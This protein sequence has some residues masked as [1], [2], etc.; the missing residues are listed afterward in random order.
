MGD[1]ARGLGAFEETTGSL[2]FQEQRDAM[3]DAK[4]I[5]RANLVNNAGGAGAGAS[6]ADVNRSH[7]L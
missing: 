7:L 4:D 1:E 5:L 3:N 6:A 2:A